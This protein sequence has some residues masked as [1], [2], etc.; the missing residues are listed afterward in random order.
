M[1]DL[2]TLSSNLGRD[3]YGQVNYGYNVEDETMGGLFDDLLSKGQQAI[4]KTKSGLVASGKKDL[5][6]ALNDPAV[7]ASTS[8]FVTDQIKQKKPQLVIVG[9]FAGLYVMASVFNLAKGLLGR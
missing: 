9:A 7:R 2:K 6:E 4:S 1:S 5:I 8:A 3:L